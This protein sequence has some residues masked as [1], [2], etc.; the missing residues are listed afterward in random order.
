LIEWLGGFLI[1][2]KTTQ[3][4]GMR[5]SILYKILGVTMLT[6][7]VLIPIKPFDVDVFTGASATVSQG[8]SSLEKVFLAIKALHNN[9]QFKGD[10]NGKDK[11]NN[12]ML[13]EMSAVLS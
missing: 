13:S 9:L 12:R 5:P 11:R 1:N 10:K 7:N 4:K 2:G 3:C 8:E 6:L